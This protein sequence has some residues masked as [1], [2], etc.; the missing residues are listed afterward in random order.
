M[1]LSHYTSREIRRRPGRTALT[2]L[3]IAIG[4]AAIVGVSITIGTT[5]RVYREM[6]EALTGRASLEVISEGQAGFDAA[7]LP[8]LES[9]PGVKLAVPVIQ[10]PAAF[11]GAEGSSGVIVLGIDPA[12]DGAVRDYLFNEGAQL[13]A[14][15]EILIGASFAESQGLKV[16]DSARLLAAS[17]IVNLRVEGILDARGAGMVNGGLSVIVSLAAAQ[18]LFGLKDRINTA[19]LV[20]EKDAI[21]RD[22]ESR[23]AAVLP[24]G[25]TVQT[26]ASR[27]E[28][29]QKGMIPTEQALSTLSAVSLVAGAFVILN[30]FLMNL[31]ERRRQIAIL[32]A[33]GATRKQVMQLLLREAALLG[34]FGT[35]TGM[36]AGVLISSSLARV[37][38]QL[39]GIR[40]GR[41]DLSPQ[42]FITA[43]LI[44]PGMALAAT[45]FPVRRAS[46]L[47]PLQGLVDRREDRAAS[48]RRWP[49]FAGIALLVVNHLVLVGFMLNWFPP[50][51]MTPVMPVMMAATLVGCALAVPLILPPLIRLAA[52]GLRPVLGIEGSLALRQLNRRLTRTGLTVGVLFIAIA[53]AVGMG[54]TLINSIKDVQDWYEGNIRVDFFIRAL[55]PDAGMIMTASLPENLEGE[56]AA[57]PGV[58]RVD[59]LSFLSARVSGKRV[60]ILA[61]TFAP[62][63]PLTVSLHGE[64]PAEVLPRVLQGE[65]ILASALAH[66]LGVKTGGEIEL[67]TPEGPKR[68]RVAGTTTEYTVGGMALFMEWNTVK[69]L[70]DHK[71]VGAYLIT[72]K[73]WGGQ[74]PEAGLRELC[75]ERGFLLQSNSEFRKL[76]ENMIGGVVGFL[77]LLMVFVFVVASLGIIN[78]L[79]MNVME[80]T[81]ELGVLRAIAMRR[82]QVRKMVLSQAFGIGLISLV[83]GSLAGLVISYTMNL[84][85]GVVFGRPLKFEIVYPFFIGACL[86]A[87][88]VAVG[89]AFLPARRATRLRIIQALQ[90]E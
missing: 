79:T 74:S 64:D 2:F 39:M 59:R 6:F 10:A 80:Q 89:S 52:R 72:S 11:M 77:W 82:G 44:G 30:T 71:G 66:E 63:Q 78:T 32:R 67:E 26:P 76:V 90:Y 62:D 15:D 19:H 87:L 4:V 29:A 61:R 12:R 57:I 40:F 16:G 20:L 69:R 56:L 34:V 17:G 73:K 33:I 24:A 13:K 46:S 21:V 14:D 9:V 22:V 25:L 81:R 5:R 50:E 49:A 48:M 68:I 75:K 36:L 8:R 88:A 38:T 45:Y 23:V 43:L 28:V 55:M 54:N 31:G 42:P 86:A 85:S 7:V 1:S 47:P 65:V 60:L 3:G 84:T 58:E 83:P 27:G 35:I 70:L 51:A 41:L 53:V 18:K 37:M